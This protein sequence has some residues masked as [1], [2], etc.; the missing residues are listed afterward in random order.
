MSSWHSPVYP[1]LFFATPTRELRNFVAHNVRFPDLRVKALDDRP[2]RQLVACGNLLDLV[3]QVTID[4]HRDF[5]L[6]LTSFSLPVAGRDGRAH[7]LTIEERDD[8]YLISAFVVRQ[9]VAASILEL[10]LQVWIRNRGT[11]LVGFRIDRQ[12]RLRAEAW[13]P[14]PGLTAEEFQLY[15]RS[16]AAEAD[17]FEYLLTGRDIE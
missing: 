7:R 3:K 11:Q 13:V 1:I 2:T 4:P 9:A 6:R 5:F 15:V 8:D 16:V 17:R 12:G 14:K 10:P